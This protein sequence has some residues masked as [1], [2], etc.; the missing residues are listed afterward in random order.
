MRQSGLQ[1]IKNVLV[2]FFGSLLILTLA[3]NVSGTNSYIYFFILLIWF[4]TLLFFELKN[5]HQFLKDQWLEFKKRKFLNIFI[6]II[7]LIIL[8]IIIN[9]SGPFFRQF[10]P[11]KPLFHSHSFPIDTWLGIFMNIVMGFTNV[12]MALVEEIAYRYELFF[13]YKSSKFMIFILLVLSSLLF[14]LSHIYNFNGSI[15]S[16]LLY[17]FAGLWLGI[18]Y[19]TTK[20]IWMPIIVHGLFNSIS[21]ISAIILLLFK[22]INLL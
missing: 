5:N 12:L 19:L 6:I 2:Y 13:K 22:I 18:I 16:S 15:I 17:A 1:Y 10:E 21:L 4:L 3:N 8:E 11:T 7:A 20:N 14:G 9:I